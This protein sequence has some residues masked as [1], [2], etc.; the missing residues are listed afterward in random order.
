MPRS[1][2][3][4]SAGLVFH[5]LNRAAKRAPLFEAPADYAAFERILR[6]AVNRFAISLFAYC[7]MPNHWHLVVRP[8][9]DRALARTMHWVTTTH[10]RRWQSAR[11]LDGHGAVYQGRYKAIPIE[12]DRHFLW[13]CRYVERNALRANLVARAEEWEWSSAQRV[14]DRGVPSFLA[15]WPVARPEGWLDQVNEPQTEA[16]LRSFRRSMREGQPFGSDEWCRGVRG[17]AGIRE[18]RRPGRPRRSRRHCP[19]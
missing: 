12:C 16:E 5:V 2:R 7:L 13:V 4:S 6:E 1:R 11:G 19:L 14:A 8:D 9:V 15:R 3:P 17:A 18:P 10:A